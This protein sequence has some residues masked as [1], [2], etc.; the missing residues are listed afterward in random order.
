[1]KKN[2][3]VLVLFGVIFFGLSIF[4]TVSVSAQGFQIITSPLPIK[5]TTTPGQIEKIKLRVKNQ[6]VNAEPISVGLMKFTA[7]KTEGS[8]NLE[9]LGPKDNYNWINFNPS[10][11]IAQPNVWYTVSMTI[12]VPKTASLGYYLA[13]TC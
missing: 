9:S 13:A 11:F 12:T 7:S 5:L 6:G 8:P 10:K 1:M 2:I 3:I 4:Y